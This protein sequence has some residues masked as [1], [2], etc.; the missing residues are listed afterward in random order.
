MKSTKSKLVDYDRLYH[1]ALAALTFCFLYI[2]INFLLPFSNYITFFFL[3][4]GIFFFTLYLI[5]KNHIS[6]FSALC[7]TIVSIGSSLIFL[8]L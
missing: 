2:E 6:L 3:A 8:Y 5:T 1:T 4:L 7:T